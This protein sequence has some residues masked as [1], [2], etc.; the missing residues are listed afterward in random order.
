MTKLNEFVAKFGK[1][2]TKEK[3]ILYR[4]LAVMLNAG[5]P[6]IKSISV[7]EKQ[8]KNPILKKILGECIT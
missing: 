1:V 8:E 7:L 6:L 2:K 3:V 5:M 4:L